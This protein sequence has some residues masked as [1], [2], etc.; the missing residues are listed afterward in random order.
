VKSAM[1]YMRLVVVGGFERG[2]GGGVVVHGVWVCGR[3]VCKWGFSEDMSGEGDAVLGRVVLK[4]K[5][6]V[7]E[8]S[9][10][11]GVD[12]EGERGS[13]RWEKHVLVLVRMMEQV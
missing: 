11:S 2:L 9:C 5:I 4:V 12:V 6:D 1:C 3:V 7:S 8:R 10:N 13:N